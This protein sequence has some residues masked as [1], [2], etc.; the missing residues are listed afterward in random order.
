MVFH[1]RES[2]SLWYNFRGDNLPWYLI[3]HHELCVCGGGD[4]PYRGKLYHMLLSPPPEEV[5][6]WDLPYGIPLGRT[7]AIWYSFRGGGGFRGEELPCDTG[8]LF[9][10]STIVLEGIV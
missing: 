4:L 6:P 3:P 1:H 7:F 8:T 10:S 2:L 5:L 9:S